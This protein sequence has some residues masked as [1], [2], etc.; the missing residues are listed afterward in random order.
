MV[1]RGSPGDLAGMPEYRRCRV[2]GGTYFFTVAIAERLR[3]LSTELIHALRRA[4][5]A[6]RIA[7]PFVVGAIVVLPDH[8]HC[9]WTLPPG[10]ADDS[11][12]WAHVKSAFSMRMPCGERRRASRVAKRERGGSQRRFRE[13]RIVDAD[14][15]RRHFDDIHFNAVKHGLVANAFAWPCSSSHR[16]VRLGAYEAGWGGMPERSGRRM[17]FSPPP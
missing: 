13:H 15:F 5:R 3:S 1:R 8:L 6:A 2:L 4:F 11:V 17:G 10:D 9:L 7:H 14:D 12:C 16:Y